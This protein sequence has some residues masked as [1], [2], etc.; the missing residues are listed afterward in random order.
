MEFAEV[1]EKGKI[2]FHFNNQENYNFSLLDSST[3]H[4]ILRMN[5]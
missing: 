4:P 1:C 2:A 3:G 5:L